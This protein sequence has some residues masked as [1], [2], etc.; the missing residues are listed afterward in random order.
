M[1]WHVVM[2]SMDIVH[3]KGQEAEAEVGGNATMVLCHSS[4]L[5]APRF[6]KQVFIVELVVHVINKKPY[7]SMRHCQY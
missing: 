7:L 1:V 6:I 3:G 5:P 4:L 2:C